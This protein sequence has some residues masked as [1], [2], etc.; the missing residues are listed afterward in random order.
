MNTANFTATVIALAS[1]LVLPM[2]F[3]AEFV[4]AEGEKFLLLD[5]KGW[6]V[7]HQND[8]WASHT[9]GGAWT[10]HGGLLG[11]PADSVGSVAVQAITIPVAGDYRVW[12][13]YQAPPYFNFSHRVEVHQDGELLYSYV[14][15][16]KESMRQWSF[17]AVS[18][19]LWWS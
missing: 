2:S 14:Y 13:R 12:S 15:G 16:R 11:A 8:S 7:T 4:F 17:G 3:A 18:D 19:Q 10:S 1:L 9:Y 6:R 5:D